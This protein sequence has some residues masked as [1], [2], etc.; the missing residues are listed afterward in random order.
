[1]MKTTYICN[2]CQKELDRKELKEFCVA[3]ASIPNI[4]LCND[5]TNEIT[6]L[7]HLK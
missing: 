2:K 3:N 7:L 1:M 4:H 5:C 6:I